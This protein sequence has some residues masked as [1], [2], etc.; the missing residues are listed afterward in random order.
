MSKMKDFL[1]ALNERG[2]QCG[3]RLVQ[4]LAADYDKVAVAACVQ[5]LEHMAANAAVMPLSRD[6]IYAVQTGLLDGANMVQDVT[7][8]GGWE[9]A[10]K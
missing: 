2:I 4:N 6:A 10:R 3:D 7:P 9:L 1:D 8:M 5:L